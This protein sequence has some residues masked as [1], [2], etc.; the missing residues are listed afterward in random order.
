M[1]AMVVIKSLVM[2]EQSQSM[3]YLTLWILRNQTTT[4]L[5]N[6]SLATLTREN[7]S[8]QSFLSWVEIKQSSLT[9]P[10]FQPHSHLWILS[11]VLQY[12][13]TIWTWLSPQMSRLSSRSLIIFLLQLTRHA[14]SLSP[15][16]SWL[17]WVSFLELSLLSCTRWW[18]VRDQTPVMTSSSAI[19]RMI[20]QF[21]NLLATLSPQS[22]KFQIKQK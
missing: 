11:M 20:E 2:K 13:F 17:L 12:H 18:V 1:D 9:T 22:Y 10:W 3:I 8:H 5:H 4:S 7:T 15:S 14:Q 21:Q 19:L 6:Q 16:V